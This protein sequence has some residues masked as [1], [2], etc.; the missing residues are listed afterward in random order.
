MWSAHRGLA[1]TARY[2]TI[3]SMI[4]VYTVSTY[5]RAVRGKANFLTRTKKSQFRPKKAIVWAHFWL[6]SGYIGFSSS[7]SS[8]LA[9]LR[10]ARRYTHVSVRLLMVYLSGHRSRRD[11]ARVI[12]VSES[13]GRRSVNS[14]TYTYIYIYIYIYVR[15]RL[16]V[17][18]TVENPTRSCGELSRVD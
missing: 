3:G 5:R 6:F 10:T 16:R 18:A 1:Y 14:H 11:N 13:C 2:A 12:Q 4:Y 8:K 7:G 17:R 9:F 15:C